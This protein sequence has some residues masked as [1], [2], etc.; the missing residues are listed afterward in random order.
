MKA[1]DAARVLGNIPEAATIVRTAATT[2]AAL[3]LQKF[4]PTNQAG[5][6]TS[7]KRKPR[8]PNGSTTITMQRKRPRAATSTNAKTR[9]RYGT[10]ITRTR[11]R[12]RRNNQ[13]RRS[14]VINNAKKINRINRQLNTL[15]ATYI[16]KQQLNSNHSCLVGRQNWGEEAGCDKE[17]LKLIL[18]NLPYYDTDTNGFTYKNMVNGSQEATFFFKDYSASMRIMNNQ[19]IPMWVRM[20]VIAPTVDTDTEAIDRITESCSSMGKELTDNFVPLTGTLA[21][22][23]P[24]LNFSDYKQLKASWRIV[25]TMYV[26]LR[27]GMSAKI[28][29]SVSNIR[30]KV[31][32]LNTHTQKFQKALKTFR[33]LFKI[34]GPLAHGCTIASPAPTNKFTTQNGVVDVRRRIRATVCYDGEADFVRYGVHNGNEQTI[35]ATD[36]YVTAIP[37]NAQLNTQ[38]EC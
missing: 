23:T 30:Y 2:L 4:I 8:K 20:Y 7:T 32:F 35:P 19:N 24:M 37:D 11:K 25:K 26:Q 3:G 21:S 14:T 31:D 15:T 36:Q 1:S 10:V 38:S 5:S 29:H 16:V 18:T 34:E 13:R 22:T 33:F 17:K 28:R 6:S 12:R 27:P 9:M